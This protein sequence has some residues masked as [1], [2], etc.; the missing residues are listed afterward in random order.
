[1]QPQRSRKGLGQ[2]LR[3]NSSEKPAWGEHCLTLETVYPRCSSKVATPHSCIYTPGSCT[4]ALTHP[5]QAGFSQCQQTEMAY[6]SPDTPYHGKTATLSVSGPGEPSQGLPFK[7]SVT[8]KENVPLSPS[9]PL[10]SP[11]SFS[12]LLFWKGRLGSVWVNGSFPSAAGSHASCAWCLGWFPTAITENLGNLQ[13]IEIYLLW[14]WTE[15]SNI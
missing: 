10:S 11:L 9:F 8:I 5:M 7:N 2:E 12:L 4:L 3:R 14:P 13:R 15:K 6:L 1:M